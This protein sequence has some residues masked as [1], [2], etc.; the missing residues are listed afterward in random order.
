MSKRPNGTGHV[1]L[2]GKT[3]TARVVDHYELVDVGKLRPKYKTKGGFKTKRE[4]INYLPTLIESTP[5]A[6][7]KPP[8]LE[9]YW[10]MYLADE[11]T[12]LS[13][14][15]QTAYQCAWKK[16]RRIAAIPISKID[17]ETLR[18]A[19]SDSCKTYYPA[20]DCKVLLTHLYKLAG[21]DG[22]ASKD[23][24]SYINL[25]GL[26]ETEREIF[27]AQEQASL[28]SLYE[29]G[30]LDAALPLTMIY[31]GMMPGEFM[32]VRAEQIDIKAQ[33]INGAGLKTKV[34]KQSPIYLPDDILPVVEDL[35]TAAQP[36][37]YLFK[38]VESDW[39]AR[40]YKALEKAGCRKLVPYCCRH[41]TATRLAITEGIAPQTIQRLMRWSTTKMLDRYAHPQSEDILS[42]ANTLRRVK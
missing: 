29:S 37:G 23:L 41:S 33:Q 27:T 12:K 13:P 38:R 32:Q 9:K 21:A 18:K 36:S 30:D 26:E 6:S 16:L 3:W 10:R 34:R 28:W 31:T 4:A 17:V 5:G 35:I 40:Y 42:A 15:K 1:Y 20:R 24:P 8:A 25:P 7:Q 2:R 19:V 14:S 22:Q 11:Y 39:Y